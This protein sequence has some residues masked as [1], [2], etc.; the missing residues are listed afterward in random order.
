MIAEIQKNSAEVV[1]VSLD[2][3]KGHRLVHLRVWYR[4]P[5]GEYRPG[6]Q[7]LALRVELLPDLRQA[8]EEA[9]AEARQQGLM[10]EAEA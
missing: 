8:L 5:L 7:G 1:R 3:F 6:K 10:P 2:E 9:D 4:D